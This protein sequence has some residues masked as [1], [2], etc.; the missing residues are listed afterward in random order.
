MSST[1]HRPP[2][3]TQIAD[4]RAS[5]RNVREK[6]KFDKAPP[7][8]KKARKG[9]ADL[10]TERAEKAERQ[11]MQ[12]HT[13]SLLTGKASNAYVRK[14]DRPQSR[15]TI[16]GLMFQIVFVVAAIG[17]GAWILDPTLVPPEWNARVHDIIGQ[18]KNHEMVRQW[19]PA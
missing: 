7:A 8:P 16:L 3:R 9:A 19:L 11:S 5:L 2:S 4:L 17:I 1:A 10:A 6:P 18:I 13:T 14:G 12:Q 15:G